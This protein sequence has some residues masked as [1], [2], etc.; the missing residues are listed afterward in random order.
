MAYI[1]AI[2]NLK[3]RCGENIFSMPPVIPL[4]FCQARLRPAVLKLRGV[5][6]EIVVDRIKL[7]NR[8]C[9]NRQRE[10]RDG[11]GQDSVA[12]CLRIRAAARTVEGYIRIKGG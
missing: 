7:R 5:H 11:I 9:P 6:V 3:G 10:R 12:V 4:K 8:I 1:N 2:K